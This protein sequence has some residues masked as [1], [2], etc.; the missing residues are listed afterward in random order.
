[1]MDEGSEARVET[2]LIKFFTARM[3]HDVIDRAIQVHGAAGISGDLP[4]E[5]MYRDARGARLYDGPDE[6]HRMLVAR[7]LLGDLER[8]A[9]WSTAGG[10]AARSGDHGRRWSP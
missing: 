5:R 8:N 7:E 2:S 4:L 10:E 3:L 6:V 1:L 9:P